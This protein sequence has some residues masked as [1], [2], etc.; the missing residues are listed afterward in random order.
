ME[1]RPVRRALV[2]SGGGGRGAYQVGVWRRLQELNWQPDL[3][4]GTSIGSL[5]GAFICSGWGADDMEQLWY[6]LHQKRVLRVSVWKRLKYRINTLLGRH[7]PWPALI[8]NGPLRD[9]LAEVLDEETLR[10]A[11]PRLTVAA[12]NV[13]RA[14]V[15]YFSA[16]QLSIEH[17][18]ASCAIPVVFPWCEIN[19]ELY[20]D[21]GVLA[22]T[23]VFPAIE[24]GATEILVVM[25]SPAGGQVTDAPRTTREAVTRMFDL[26]TLGSSQSLSQALALQ[27]G[28]DLKA[29]T[30]ALA[31]SGEVVLGET[32]VGVVAPRIDPGI[33]SVLD[34][35]P[36]HIGPR[37]EAGYRDATEQLAQF[38]N[39]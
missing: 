7:P 25:L 4:C 3:V 13:R 6:S 26:V 22:N 21:G 27:Y 8:D 36:K 34:L 2:L 19:G 12:T 5:N 17:L 24:A 33:S 20:W 10:Q 35:D 39:G 29:H 31:E 1:T 28:R 9:V 32:R 23:P 18:L 15:E 38:S 16:E 11:H 30:R 37:I 14:M